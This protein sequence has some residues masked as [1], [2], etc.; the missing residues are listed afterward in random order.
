MNK[1]A[2]AMLVYEELLEAIA[3]EKFT[4]L[5]QLG[6]QLTKKLIELQDFSKSAMFF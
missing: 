1:V 2:L 3:S 5:F 6:C 4:L